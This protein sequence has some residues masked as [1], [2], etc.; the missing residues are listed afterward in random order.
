MS[1]TPVYIKPTTAPIADLI[2]QLN[3]AM[4]EKYDADYSLAITHGDGV[5]SLRTNITG[6]V[7]PIVEPP[8]QKQQVAMIKLLVRYDAGWI[9]NR[10]A[11]FDSEI[12]TKRDQSWI[13]T[14]MEC[15]DNELIVGDHAYQLEMV[16][17][18]G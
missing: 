7:S 3:K 18:D 13:N 8:K 15:G 1:N 10:S 2:E 9:V 5:I 6:F 14:M 16:E 17:V 12:W 4:Q 11:H